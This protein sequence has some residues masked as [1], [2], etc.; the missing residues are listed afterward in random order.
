[1]PSERHAS[2]CTP[3]FT[4]IP[5]ASASAANCKRY[6]R[7]LSPIRF[8]RFPFR[9]LS[10]SHCHCLC[11][12]DIAIM[13]SER[14]ASSCHL[15]AT[16]ACMHVF[17]KTTT[18]KNITLD[19]HRRDTI[20]NQAARQYCRASRLRNSARLLRALSSRRNL[21]CYNIDSSTP[22]LCTC[23]SACLVGMRI[24]FK[25]MYGIMA[26]PSRSKLIA[27]KRSNF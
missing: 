25:T 8:S 4:R 19:V 6:R 21:G 20:E 22:A 3:N 27:T 16:A 5:S 23:L 9:I 13:P 26:G 14:H 17:V 24:F 12:S 11:I 15:A 7:L 18:S 2:L 1:M 10:D